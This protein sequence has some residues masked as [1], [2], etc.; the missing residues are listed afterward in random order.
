MIFFNQHFNKSKLR[1][2]IAWL[3]N[4]SG[5]WSTI[6]AL[7]RLKILGFSYATKAGISLSI[8]DLSPPPAKSGFVNATSNLVKSSY[9]GQSLGSEK[10]QRVIDSWSSASEILKDAIVEHFLQTDPLN[11]VYIMAFSGARG[12]LT[13]VRQLIGMRGLMVDPMGNILTLPVQHSFR[14]GLTVTEYL[15]SCYGA[16]KGLVDTAL[17]TA[18]SGYL[19][20][21][22][23]DV[24]QDV[25]VR[26]LDCG[27]KKGIVLE[28]LVS[29]D[30]SIL[31]PL[32]KRLLG[33]ILVPSNQVIDRS[34]LGL[35]QKKNSVMVRS[36]LLCGSSLDGKTPDVCQLCYGWNLGR[37]QAVQVGEAVGI[38]AAQSI[39]EPGTQLT[40]RTFHT[41]G[42]VA[43]QVSSRLRASQA[44]RV[45][46][47][48]RSSGC[49]VR[50]TMGEIA[51][52]TYEKSSF[53]IFVSSSQ[54]GLCLDYEVPAGT[55]LLVRHGQW[56]RR[57][58]D[59]AFWALGSLITNP[60]LKTYKAGT[61]FH[62]RWIEDNNSSMGLRSVWLLASSISTKFNFACLLGDIL[63]CGEVQIESTK[64]KGYDYKKISPLKADYQLNNF[65][66]EQTGLSYKQANFNTGRIVSWQRDW[67]SL[68]YSQRLLSQEHSLKT[69]FSDKVKPEGSWVSR[70]TF[71]GFFTYTR[72][73]SGDIVQGLPKI[74]ALFEA[75]E[76]TGLSQ[77]LQDEFNLLRRGGC[78]NKEAAREAFYQIQ[79]VL[80]C[81]IQSAYLD[82]GVQ[83][84]DKH[85]E[86]IVRQMTAK[87]C[88]I[89]P[90]MS[91]YT[92]GEVISL[93]EAEAAYDATKYLK[94]KVV[95]YIPVLSGITK[96]SLEKPGFLSPASFQDTI[97]VLLRC[98]LESEEDPV[99]GLKE[100]VILGQCVPSGTA[101]QLKH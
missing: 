64:F 21:R 65:V 35:L 81:R 87:V 73:T 6:Q 60:I 42:A 26:S 5:G 29:E 88:I 70:G 94:V 72:P 79:K 92:L 1:L 74:D 75:R 86:I 71:L 30:G 89:R 51:F 69:S 12:S 82:Q 27:T 101:Y 91:N 36:P 84:D 63:K 37:N 7:E 43:G 14:E 97:R 33:R 80:V 9:G 100:S 99:R 77:K 13:Q 56:V 55:C 8:D 38:V 47:S 66:M 59:I 90:G 49:L 52:L 31:L 83:I 17:R 46:F 18:K 25:V 39:G 93:L 68:Q 24:A 48:K 45:I 95:E 57:F 40:M 23:V 44:G 98:S 32:K 28:N 11:P 96:A 3:L 41:G 50:T 22:L 20:R 85:I 10:I 53:S 78:S 58:E 15:L 2:F 34:L 62:G 19:T 76:A 54:N 4:S 16:R 67:V 61:K